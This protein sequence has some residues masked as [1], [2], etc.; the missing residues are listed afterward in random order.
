MNHRYQCPY[1]EKN[2]SCYD[3][4]YYGDGDKDYAEEDCPYD[5]VE[6]FLNKTMEELK[7]ACL[8]YAENAILG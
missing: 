3:C 6:E 1:W 5:E 2:G 7:D 4:P 8:K